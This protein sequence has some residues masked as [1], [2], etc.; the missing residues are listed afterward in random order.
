MSRIAGIVSRD[1]EHSPALFNKMMET[2]AAGAAWSSRTQA[3][4]AA[5]FGW[6]GWQTPNIVVAN[7]VLVVMDGQIY[8]RAEWGPDQVD[9]ALVAMLY[10]KHG[11]AATLRRLNGDFAIAVYDPEIETLWLAR[12]RFG[13]KPLYYVSNSTAFGFASQPRAL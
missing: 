10:G 3:S 13:L 2:W 9:A 1:A 6:L 8:N 11:F 12:D 5:R 7:G 4:G